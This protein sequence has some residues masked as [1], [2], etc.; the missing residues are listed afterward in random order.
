MVV[1]VGRLMLEQMIR[2]FVKHGMDLHTICAC[3][4]EKPHV[5]LMECEPHERRSCEGITLKIV[6]QL[7]G[8]LS[9]N[10]NSSLH[11]M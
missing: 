11:G 6:P 4:S 7:R 9:E 5:C 3:L 8:G 1:F 10:N 2:T